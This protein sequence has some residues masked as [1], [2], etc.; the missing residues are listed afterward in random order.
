M[1]ASFKINMHVRFQL[2]A[3]LESDTDAQVCCPKRSEIKSCRLP[4]E[5]LAFE[6]RARFCKAEILVALHLA[7]VTGT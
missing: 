3:L 6:S 4:L 7:F 5:W 1:H 2:F